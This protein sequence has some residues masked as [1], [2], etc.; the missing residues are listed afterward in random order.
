MT[1]YLE[2]H[3]RERYTVAAYHFHPF[4]GG[5]PPMTILLEVGLS[6]SRVIVFRDLECLGVLDTRGASTIALERLRPLLARTLLS[7]CARR[8]LKGAFCCG[9][10]P[11]GG[12]FAT[13]VLPSL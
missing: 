12:A 2:S 10:W 6:L 9:N 4:A 11:P 3:T 5:Q 1:F 7:T 13:G 8:G